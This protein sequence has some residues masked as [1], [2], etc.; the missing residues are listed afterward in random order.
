MFIIIIWFIFA[1]IQY[2]MLKKILLV[3]IIVFLMF[4]LMLF[5]TLKNKTKD[6]SKIQPYNTVV[7]KE[8][9]L[10]RPVVL[11]K[12]D[13]L[14]KT[15]EDYSLYTDTL[16]YKETIKNASEHYTLSINTP[17]KILSAKHFNHAVSGI[18]ESYIIGSVIHPKT[19]EVVYFEFN[20]AEEIKDAYVSNMKRKWYFPLAPWQKQTIEGTFEFKE[21]L[22]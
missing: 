3:L 21:P 8:F 17:I 20:W 12:N 14:D 10:H 11:C 19:K 6:V 15:F 4:I 1:K 5:Y 13:A 16:Y 9:N 18:T 22:F 7:G 2:L